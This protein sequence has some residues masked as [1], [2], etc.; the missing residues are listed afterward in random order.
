MYRTV[1][2]SVRPRASTSTVLDDDHVGR[3]TLQRALDDASGWPRR[4]GRCSAR[5]SASSRPLPKSGR[6]TRSPGAV[7]STCSMRSR[8]W[9]SG[10][11]VGGATPL[12]DVRRESRCRSCDAAHVA[13][14][15]GWAKTGSIGV[16]VGTHDR[17]AGLHRHDGTP[18]RAPAPR[19]PPTGPVTQGGDGP[20]RS[21]RSPRSTYGVARVDDRLPADQS[22]AGRARS[23]GAVPAWVHSTV[24]PRWMTGPGIVTPSPSARRR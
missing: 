12:V 20:C 16:P 21:A 24:A 9:S 4:A 23:A 10:S 11:V 7:N 15:R 22:P 3:A 18:R 19:R 5:R 17:R 13:I 8:R 14:T 1:T 6:I 2:D